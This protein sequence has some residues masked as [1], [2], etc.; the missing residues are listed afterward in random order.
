MKPELKVCVSSQ[1]SLEASTVSLLRPL[2]DANVTMIDGDAV[3]SCHDYHVLINGDPRREDLTASPALRHVIMPWAGVS[4]RLRELLKEFPSI[5]LHNSHH[6][7]VTTGEMAV[8]LLMAA[9]RQIPPVDRKMHQL[10][11]SP[12]EHSDQINYVLWGQTALILGFG[13]IGQHVGGVCQA[14][15]M[16]VVGIRRDAT[17]PIEPGLKAE[18]YT[19]DKLNQVLPRTNVLIITMPHTDET[20]G[21]IGR[22]QFALMPDDSLLVNVGRG[23]VVDQFALYEALTNGK[24]RAAGID[25]WYHYPAHGVQSCQPADAPLH[26]LEN[27]VMS[28]H[29]GGAGGTGQAEHLRA[30]EMAKM[31]NAAARGEAM[32]NRVNLDLGY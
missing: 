1:T 4:P 5:S 12:R 18:V 24:L 9:A 26:E 15:G 3:Q 8:A 2:L 21:M 17:K 7:A 28:P 32:P 29:R 22:E 20:M 6:N 19:P 10:D 27:V 25:V 11:W 14:L 16:E 31:L 13:A 23:A 30:R